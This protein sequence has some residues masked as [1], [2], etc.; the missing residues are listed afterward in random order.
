MRLDHYYYL[1]RVLPFFAF[2]AG[3]EVVETIITTLLEAGNVDWGVWAVLK[4]FAVFVVELV[5]AFLY[6]MVPYFLYL[7][8]LPQKRH[9]GKFDRVATCLFFAF[10]LGLSLFEEIAEGFFWDEFSSTF[11]FIAVDYLIYTKEV[12]GNIYQSYPIIPIMSALVVVVALVTWLMRKSL[13]PSS[14]APGFWKR[15][16]HLIGLLLLCGLSFVS[17]DTKDT[18]MTGNRYNTELAKDGMYSL[19]SA[20]LKNELSYKEYYPT[21]DERQVAAFLQKELNEPGTVFLA[22]ETGS[23]ARTIHNP[24]QEIHPNVVIVVMESMGAEFL[25]ENRKDGLILTP[26]LSR[27]GAE[28]VFFPH[29]YATGTRSVRGLEAVSTS[30]L[31]LPGM[32]ILRKEGNEN[33]QT[34]GSI[35]QQKGYEDRKW[36]YGGYGYFDNMNYYFGNNGFEVLDR[37]TMDDKDI[38]HSTV[39]GVCDEDL[40]RRCIQEADRSSASGKPF[41][42][43]V[44]TTSN[45]RPYTYPDGRIDIPSKTGRNGAVKYADYAVGEF[46]RQAKMKPWF[47]NTVFL[48]IADHGAGSAGKKDLNPET[49]LIPLIIYAP[50]LIKPERYDMPISQI[51]A[52]PTLLGLLNWT[53]DASFYGKD[54][55]KPGYRSRYFISNYQNIG[56]CRGDGMIVL[57]PVKEAHYYKN[58]EPVPAD[59]QAEEMLQEA[60]NYY[61]HASGWRKNLPVASLPAAREKK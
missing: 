15:F 22:P 53:Y 20:F 34:V 25:P 58:G 18:D 31:P 39:W 36:I 57:K 24:E 9:G 38:T 23:I 28:G 55:R 35:F 30:I 10:F 40:F 60:I 50:S 16:F 4:T 14:P 42:Q 41:L 8:V 29:T 45:H 52:L 19:F 6:W 47:D 59:A 61:Q 33:L 11:N 44:F 2:F 51:D 1:R 7:L 12:I 43:F 5:I 13:V 54:A 46:I 37:T 26:N 27:L 3:I 48:F 32:A 49:H 17:F 21:T 56:Y